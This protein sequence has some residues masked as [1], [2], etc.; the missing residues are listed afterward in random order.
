[1]LPPV[2]AD[3]AV[4]EENTLAEHRL[5]QAVTREFLARG[6]EETEFGAD[7]TVRVS[8]REVERT[9]VRGSGWIRIRGAPGAF[10]HGGATTGDRGATGAATDTE[11]MSGRVATSKARY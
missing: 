4:D 7:L 3:G 8:S 10:T 5:R 2:R 9:D 11:A 1:M 6:L